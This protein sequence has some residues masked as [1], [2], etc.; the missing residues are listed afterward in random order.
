MKGSLSFCQDF[1]E[2]LSSCK[3]RV[4]CEDLITI[5]DDDCAVE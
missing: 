5:R 4:Y 3:N 1:F 2:D